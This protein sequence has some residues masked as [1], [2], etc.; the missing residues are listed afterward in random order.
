MDIARHWKTGELLPE[1]EFQKLLNCKTFNTGL[2]TLRQVHLAL[3]DLKLHSEWNSTLGIKPDELRREIA[4]NTTVL[5]PIKEDH[6]LCSFNHIFAGGYSAGYYSYKWAEVLSSDAYSA[7]EVA[8]NSNNTNEIKT[9]GK[10]FKETILSLGGSKAP[11]EIF[12]DFRGR[13]ATTK[14]L[15]RHSGLNVDQ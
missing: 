4:K 9:I 3:T 5:D 6:L 14:A 15:I 2:T 10:R 8:N 13:D 12:K 11:Q 1:K 7:F